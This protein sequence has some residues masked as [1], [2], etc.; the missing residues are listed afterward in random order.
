MNENLGFFEKLAQALSAAGPYI[1]LGAGIISLVMIVLLLVLIRKQDRLKARMDYFM[2][3]GKKEPLEESLRHMVDDNQTMKQQLRTAGTE[4]GKLRAEMQTSYRKTGVVKYNA[5]PGMAGKMSSSVA[6]LNNENNGIVIT[7]IHGQDGC[8]T[9]IK[10]IKRGASYVE[11]S[12][13]EQLALEKAMHQDD[14]YDEDMEGIPTGHTGNL[15]RA[16]TL[17]LRRQAAAKKEKEENS[18]TE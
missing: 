14:F 1:A 6:L 16:Y 11:L 12:T 13:E 7:S 2:R 15:K 3:G 5:F 17:A 10:E 4:L 8:Y 9:Y 18:T